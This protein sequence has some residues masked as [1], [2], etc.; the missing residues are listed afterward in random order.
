MH[1]PKSRRVLIIVQCVVMHAQKLVSLTKAIPCPIVLA[2][3]ILGTV[4]SN[5]KEEDECRPRTNS[6][7]ICLNRRM[8]VLHLHKLVT[9]E[10]PCS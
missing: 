7:S 5:A 10:R 8:R 3:D 2:I 1:I 4:N 6:T 9:H